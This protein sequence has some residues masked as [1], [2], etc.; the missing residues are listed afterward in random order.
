MSDDLAR[1]AH[2]VVSID[3]FLRWEPIVKRKKII[4]AEKPADNWKPLVKRILNLHKLPSIHW[5][6]IRKHMYWKE[7]KIESE[8]R[9][10]Q[11]AYL[12]RARE[13]GIIRVEKVPNCGPN[14][15]RFPY[16]SAIILNNEHPLVGRLVEEIRKEN[17]EMRKENDEECTN[18]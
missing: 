9:K 11:D 14:K 15:E 4:A 16:V 8:D 7:V 12:N 13:A 18:L 1:A 3:T 2:E 5:H 10:E 17:E 6:Y